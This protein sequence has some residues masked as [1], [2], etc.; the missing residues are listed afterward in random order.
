MSDSTIASDIMSD[1]KKSLDDIQKSLSTIQIGERQMSKV[2]QLKEESEQLLGGEA[3]PETTSDD[4]TPSDDSAEP[5]VLEGKK[6]FKKNSSEYKQQ[7][8]KRTEEEQL[9]AKYIQEKDVSALH[10]KVMDKLGDPVDS[11]WTKD[12][13]SGVLPGGKYT[14]TDSLQSRADLEKLPEAVRHG[15]GEMWYSDAWG[16]LVEPPDWLTISHFGS[17]IPYHA[18]NT[19]VS[20]KLVLAKSNLIIA[21]MRSASSPVDYDTI[22]DDL[23]DP[24]VGLGLEVHS[25]IRKLSQSLTRFTEFNNAMV[26]ATKENLVESEK[27]I[28]AVKQ[29]MASFQSDVVPSMENKSQALTDALSTIT[30]RSDV[31]QGSTARGSQI[32]IP[33]GSQSAPS[34]SGLSGASGKTSRDPSKSQGSKKPVPKCRQKPVFE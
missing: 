18:S 2:K 14:V 19:E 4:E 6:S 25:G 24:G 29:L 16:N 26:E 12:E 34:V 9:R 8:H 10:I 11:A 20:S 33:S 5:V 1:A 22:I 15:I 23:P 32:N 13:R 30:G 3:T 21:Q 27:Q 31:E 17:T 7:Q 28:C